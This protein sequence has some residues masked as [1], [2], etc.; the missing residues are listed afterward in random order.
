MNKISNK[1]SARIY[2]FPA[3]GR[4]GLSGRRDALKPTLDA[5]ALLRAPKIEFGSGW[6]HEAAMEAEKARKR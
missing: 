3:N 6:Y 5:A 4:A 2:Q 1:E